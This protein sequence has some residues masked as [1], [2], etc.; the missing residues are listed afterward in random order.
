MK[1]NSEFDLKLRS[2]YCFCINYLQNSIFKCLNFI[3]FFVLVEAK[4]HRQTIFL[5]A[6]KMKNE[7]NVLIGPPNLYTNYI[8]SPVQHSFIFSFLCRL[9]AS[10]CIPNCFDHIVLYVASFEKKKGTPSRKRN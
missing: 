2:V 10:V 3:F 6:S 4:L 5:I 7:E 8:K 1:L 9:F